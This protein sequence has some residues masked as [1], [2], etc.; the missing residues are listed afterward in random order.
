MQAVASEVTRPY[1]AHTD[2]LRSDA[3][4]I[5]TF[6]GHAACLKAVCALPAINSIFSASF[7]DHTVRRWS[8]VREDVAELYFEAV[9]AMCI[10]E[11]FI[12]SGN[13]SGTVQAFTLRGKPVARV[14]VYD[15]HSVNAICA[16]CNLNIFTG[17]AHPPSCAATV[18]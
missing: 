14:T 2:A 12:L 5:R 10:R 15:S 6:E 18:T 13:A 4:C 16:D 17:G 7:F 3:V 11:P 9:T 1:A 8:L